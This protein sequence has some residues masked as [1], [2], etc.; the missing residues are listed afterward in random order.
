MAETKGTILVVDDEEAIRNVLARK[1]ETEGYTCETACDGQDALWK[2]FMQDFDLVLSDIKM[3]G[4]S[5][6]EVLSQI[7]TD[8]PDTGVIMITAMSDIQTAVKAMRSGAYDY[9][10]KPFNLDDLIVRVERGLERRRL[11]IENREYQLR[12]EQKVERQ[13][14]LAQQ[15]YQE[16]IE[17]LAREEMALEKLYA[18]QMGERRD[19]YTDTS[20]QISDD[21]EPSIIREFAK[22]ISQLIG[23]G[24][25]DSVTEIDDAQIGNPDIL[26][27]ESL[28]KTMP[29]EKQDIVN[30]LEDESIHTT[31]SQAETINT[32]SDIPIINRGLDEEDVSDLYTGTVEIVTMPSVSLST[33]M[34]M[35]EHLKDDPRIQIVNMGGS[36]DKGLIVK[37]NLESPTPILQIVSDL[38]EVE[39]ATDSLE[40]IIGIESGRNDQ[41]PTIKKIVVELIKKSTAESANQTQDQ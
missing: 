8:H 18:L 9:V 20:D 17:A 38:P 27:N 33:V 34:Q 1:L 32:D 14:G 12:L 13:I 2:A 41:D 25:P 30:L 37:L 4:M 7:T 28:E 16:A 10:T 29:S 22:K 21:N 40:E 6:L 19:S 26:A 35:N 3:P 5:G 24:V 15:Y 23:G 11:I 31:V 36:V 39:N